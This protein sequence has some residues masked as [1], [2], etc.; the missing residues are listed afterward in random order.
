MLDKFDMM[1]VWLCVVW[2]DIDLLCLEVFVIIVVF[3][4]FDEMVVLKVGFVV[5]VV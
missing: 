2:C 4:L 3:V 5:L 1:F